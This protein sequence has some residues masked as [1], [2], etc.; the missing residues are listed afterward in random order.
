MSKDRPTYAGIAGVLFLIFILQDAALPQTPAQ[1]QLTGPMVAAPASI[2]FGDVVVGKTKTAHCTVKNSSRATMILASVKISNPAFH[3]IAPALP[4][5]VGPDETVPVALAFSP[6]TSEPQ[7]GSIAIQSKPAGPSLL[8]G[9][10]GR[11]LP[12]GALSLSPP[13]LDFGALDSGSTAERPVTVN[14]SGFSGVTISAAKINGENFNL[15]G[16]SHPVTLSPAQS[17]TFTVRYTAASA[18]PGHGALRLESNAAVATPEMSLSA[19][20][21]PQGQLVVTPRTLNFGQVMV[22]RSRRVSLRF[23]ASRA[24]VVVSSISTGSS[25]F[26]LVGL[27]TPF[28]I[29]P[30][31]SRTVGL[32]FIP[33]TKGVASASLSLASSAASHPSVTLRGLGVLAARRR[34]VLEWAASN[35]SVVGYNVYRSG[36]PG[37]PYARINRQTDPRTAFTDNSVAV[38]ETYYYVVTSVDSQG[39]Q[40]ANSNEVEASIPTL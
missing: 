26:V 6:Q 13:S 37:G 38:G 15:S 36:V 24:K 40:S 22:G 17:I 27:R 4:V 16:L 29:Q 31:A 35:S 21:A 32:K 18:S 7:A 34:V 30:G 28:Q 25:E 10:R 11:A 23:T 33:Q 19:T 3:W 1:P 20:T 5:I 8:L 2:E 9:L 39:L 14:N 12:A